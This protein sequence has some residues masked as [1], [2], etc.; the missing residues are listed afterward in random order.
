MVLNIQHYCLHDGPGIRTT[1]FLKGCSLRCKWCC[2]PEG[3]SP[4]QE[5]AYNLNK[6]IGEK[7]CGACL[8]TCPESAIYVLDSDGRVR[9]NWYLCVNCGACVP[10]CPSKALY[11][12]GREMT[13]DQVI[14]EVESDSPFYRDSGGGISLSGGECL[15]QPDFSAA[16][17]AEAHRRGIH[18]AIE[19]ASNVPWSAMEKVLPYVDTVLHDIKLMDSKRHKKWT[20]VDNTRILANLH[21]AYETFPGKTFIAR[22]PLIPGVNDTE[23]DIRAVLAFIS[24]YSQVAK[25]ELV[26]YHRFGQSKYEYLGK[27]Y[28][29]KDFAS[30]PPETIHRLEAIIEEAFV[31]KSSSEK[32][33]S[34][35]I[36]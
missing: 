1:V 19:T 32:G 24:D 10:I 17:L 25:Y 6:C 11:L 35:E 26:P 15:L 28:D 13:V 33:H 36:G 2:N 9:I 20:G 4:R 12:F 8:K 5:L 31:S 27:V 34:Q 29:L 23:K 30:P 16:V 3:L 7:D 22:T 14:E 21:R 18:T